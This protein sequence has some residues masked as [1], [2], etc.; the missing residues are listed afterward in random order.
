MPTDDFSDPSYG[1]LEVLTR[2][3]VLPWSQ[4]WFNG[5]A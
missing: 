1:V 3:D 4:F 5:A 2:A